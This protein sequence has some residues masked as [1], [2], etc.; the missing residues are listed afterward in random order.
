LIAACYEGLSSAGIA[1][2][3]PRSTAL[4]GLRRNFYSLSA[5][6]GSSL[7]TEAKLRAGSL[8][9]KSNGMESVPDHLSKMAPDPTD[10]T[11][12]YREALVNYSKVTIYCHH[13]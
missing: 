1:V 12:K 11:E 3:F 9:S 2:N 5:K 8:N 6:R 7:L 4:S 13:C 10:I